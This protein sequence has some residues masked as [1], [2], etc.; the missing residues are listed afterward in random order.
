M[1]REKRITPLAQTEEEYKL[2]T[3]VLDKL[4]RGMERQIPVSTGF[5]TLREQALVKALVPECDFYGGSEL[6]ERRIAYYLPDYLRREDYL[7]EGPVMCLRAGFYD[8][9][10]LSHRD[11]LGALMGAGIRR[12]AVGDICVGE[13]HCDFFVLAELGDYLLEHL[14]SA[15]RQHLHMEKIPTEQAQILPPKLKELSVTVAT[16][17]LDS[18]LAAG[19][20]LSRATAQE[21]IRSGNVMLDGL[22]CEKTDRNVSVLSEISLRGKGKFRILAAGGLSRKGRQCLTLGLF[23]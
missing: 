4:E 14:T 23:L 16:M 19:F 1:E 17:R 10:A 15:G 5:L 11:M 7:Q 9:N 8:K 18:V 2:L 22:L 3:R 6:S 21:Q 13:K 12:D 20:K